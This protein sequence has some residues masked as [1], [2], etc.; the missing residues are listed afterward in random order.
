MKGSVQKT[1]KNILK[2]YYQVVVI[3]ILLFVNQLNA[4]L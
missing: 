3:K 4:I 1:Q 2:G